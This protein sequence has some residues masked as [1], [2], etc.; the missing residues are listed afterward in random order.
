MG[1]AYIPVARLGAVP[2]GGMVPVEVGGR[3]MLLAE[4]AGKYFVFGRECPHEAADLATGVL[5]Q[6]QI[7]CANHGY[8]FDVASGA[9]VVPPGG[10][11]L[12]TLPVEVRGEEICVRLEW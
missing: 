2:P 1:V 10:P 8:A 7:R 11:A 3:P 12:T 4:S 6:S 5:E 9:C